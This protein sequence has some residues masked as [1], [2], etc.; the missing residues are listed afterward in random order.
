MNAKSEAIA[1]Y[2]ELKL[3]KRN[4]N[5]C[6]KLISGYDT[7]G[8][9]FPVKTV[10]SLRNFPRKEWWFIETRE[11][12]LYEWPKLPVKINVDEIEEVDGIS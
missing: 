10:A 7:E 1:S 11:S 4:W 8:Y 9:F 3:L 2:L 12:L 5:F 6:V